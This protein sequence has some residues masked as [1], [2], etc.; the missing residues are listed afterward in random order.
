MKGEDSLEQRVLKAIN[1]IKPYLQ[2]DGG[3]MEFIDITSDNVVRIELLG[4]CKSC[5]MN[6]YTFQNGIKESILRTVP[7][8]KGVQAI[9][10]LNE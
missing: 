4:S 3:D 10:W 5:S 1:L 7:E 9:N 8:V 6:S 2:E